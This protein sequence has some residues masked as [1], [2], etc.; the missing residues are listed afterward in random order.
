MTQ[1]PTRLNPCGLLL[2]LVVASMAA[3]LNVRAMGLDFGG[4]GDPPPSVP[5]LVITPGPM[6]SPVRL[7]LGNGGRGNL[8]VTDYAGSAVYRVDRN[9]PA[10]AEKLFAVRGRPLGIAQAGPL[11]VFV[12]NESTG[13]V[14]LYT[15]S[16]RLLG[17]YRSTAP[18]VPSDLVFD[19]LTRRL[20]VVDSAAGDVKVFNL[21]GR[22]LQTIDGFGEIFHPMG[23]AIDPQTRRIA[24]SDFGD[25]DTG[26]EPSIQLF[27]Y[28]GARL[29]KITGA[30]S[31]PRGLAF[32]GQRLLMVDALLGQV[33]VFDT[34]TGARLAAIGSFGTDPGQLLFPLDVAFDGASQKLYV[35]NNRLGRVTD[36]AAGF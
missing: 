7:D 19:Q 2:L 10:V 34:T 22:V 8:L 20:F 12:G 27:D 13:R 18:M 6:V 4:G 14:E 3:A 28:S 5:T 31:S 24:I 29:L 23:V 9:N 26:I 36:L 30:F 25:P 1:V 33:L 21:R 35:T 16:G 17:S 32:A 15:T 11:R